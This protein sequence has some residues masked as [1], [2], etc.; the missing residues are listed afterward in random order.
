MRDLWQGP[1]VG[2]QHF[3]FPHPH[4]TSLEPQHSTRPRDRQGHPKARQRLR[5][6]PEGWQSNSLVRLAAS[7]NSFRTLTNLQSPG[8]AIL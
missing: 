3:P 7:F 1:I 8:F 2:Q 4:L 6:L 5:L